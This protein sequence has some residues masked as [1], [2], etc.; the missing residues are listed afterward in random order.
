MK[1]KEKNMNRLIIAAIII[2][3][4][5]T[6]IMPHPPN[7]TPIIAMGLFGGAYL[8]DKRWAVLLPVGAMLLADVF[9]GFHGTMIWVY[10]SLIIITTIGFLLRRG[11][12]LQSG[13]IATI[14]GSLLFFLV[15]NFGVWASGSFYPKNVEGLISC[16]AAGIPF[17]G[18]TLGGSIFYSFLMFVGYE[19]M[20]NY[21]P[22]SVPDSIRK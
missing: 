1:I 3:A 20:K 8:K 7:F 10:G 18:N 12:T 21:L 5:F 17:F 6:R 14:S 19:V 16:Y 15:T 11:V 13:A 4:A 22:D 2:F 9:L